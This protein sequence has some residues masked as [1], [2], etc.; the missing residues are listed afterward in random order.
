[1]SHIKNGVL[2]YNLQCH[3]VQNLMGPGQR[4][5]KLTEKAILH[6]N[7]MLIYRTNGNN[8]TYRTV[9]LYLLQ[10]W[11]VCCVGKQKEL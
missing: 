1:M 10:Q 8:Q 2:N 5:T 9:K 4:K 7:V 6:A 3:M 11:L